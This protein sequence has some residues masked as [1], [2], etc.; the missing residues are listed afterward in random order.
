MDTRFRVDESRVVYEILEGEVV[1]V[2]LDTGHYY[3]LAD[4]A[5]AVW[6]ML[7]GG[8]TPAE[9]VRTLSL[10][11]PDSGERVRETILDFVQ[12]L[13][14]EDLLTASDDAG[15]PSDAADMPAP[16]DA[17]A[18]F[19]PPVLNRYTDMA[20]LI[21]MDPIHDFDETGWPRRPTLQDR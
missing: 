6:R 12:Q 10:R 4:T 19:A 14:A 11:H 7:V 13:A 17:A 16:T 18:S 15:P 8:A 1:V 20:T 5:A 21:Q 9:V 3:I 2:N